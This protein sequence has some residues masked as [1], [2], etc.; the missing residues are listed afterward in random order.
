VIRSA[1][2][3]IL[4]DEGKAQGVRRLTFEARHAARRFREA[5]H[6]ACRQ[7]RADVP[8]M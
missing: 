4:D 6:A 5:A 1:T 2:K 8:A 7:G 3:A